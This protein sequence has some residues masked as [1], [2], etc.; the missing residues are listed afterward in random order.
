[1][2]PTYQKQ[3][4]SV[5]RPDSERSHHELHV[6]LHGNDGSTWSTSFDFDTAISSTR[7]M[8]ILQ[9]PAKVEQKGG[10]IVSVTDNKFEVTVQLQGP[11][12]PA[13]LIDISAKPI[14]D[15][16][17]SMFTC[18]AETGAA[19]GILVSGG[20]VSVTLNEGD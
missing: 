18:F 5:L 10:D 17:S 9:L 19:I 7:K 14:T 13:T 2:K 16:M 8:L 4:L 6:I 15:W 1:M 12:L 20:R 11:A 3:S